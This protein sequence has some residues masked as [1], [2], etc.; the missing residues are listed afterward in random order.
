VR[1]SEALWPWAAFCILF[2]IFA[3]VAPVSFINGDAVVYAEQ[4]RAANF[5]ERT[6]HLGYYIVAYPVSLLPI[7]LSHA[8]NLLNCAFGAGAVVLVGLLAREITGSRHIGLLAACI[9]AVNPMVVGNALHAE[10]YMSQSMFMLAGVYL[11]R[12]KSAILSGA[13]IAVAFLVTSS[14]ALAGPFFVILR[15]QVKALAT[16]GIVALLISAAAL[17]PVLSNY[18]YGARGFL[19]ALGHGIDYKLAFLKSGRDVFF[20]FFAMM[21]YLIA[22]A[23]EC[24]RQS[25]LRRFGLALAVLWLTVFAFGEKFLDV[26]VQL[27]T[28]LLAC[29]VAAIG[30]Q[31]TYSGERK[32]ALIGTCAAFGTVAMV[33]A[34]RSHV[35][36]LYADHL[37]SNLLLTVLVGTLAFTAVATIKA[38]SRRILVAAACVALMGNAFVVF[39]QEADTRQKLSEMETV[40]RRIGETPKSAFVAKWNTM[41]RVNWLNHAVAYQPDGFDVDELDGG[42]KSEVARS[43]FKQALVQKEAVFLLDA[44][45]S[46]A[47]LLSENG[48]GSLDGVVFR[49]KPAA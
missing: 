24:W 17:A 3:A 41:V 8:L 26:P 1:Y 33:L 11:W 6:T 48:F 49:R 16:L 31:A 46:I 7:S 38:C 4:I 42:Y 25:S 23:I 12:K 19:G 18:L 30:V 2:L 35:P 9:A 47:R 22:G 13:S 39:Q 44:T 5:A 20:G 45:P 15:P 40:A 27:P 28:Y 29:I 43:R 32:A 37:P 34:V 10:V 21:P 36:A 14:T